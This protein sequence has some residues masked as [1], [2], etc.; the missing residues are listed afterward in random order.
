MCRTDH[1]IELEVFI[2]CDS[3]SSYLHHPPSLSASFYLV[4]LFCMFLFLSIIYSTC[5]TVIQLHIFSVIPLVCLLVSP[6]SLFCLLYSLCLC[7]VAVLRGR[8]TTGGQPASGQHTPN[9]QLIVRE[10]REHVVERECRQAVKR[11]TTRR[12]RPCTAIFHWHMI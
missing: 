2:R 8:E 12:D 11:V 3:H 10:K 7:C 1:C 9:E 5:I 6:L 4:L